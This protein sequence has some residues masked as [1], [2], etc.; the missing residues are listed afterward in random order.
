MPGTPIASLEDK[1][2]RA[3]PTKRSNKELIFIFENDDGEQQFVMI[4][5]VN[6]FPYHPFQGYSTLCLSCLR[7]ISA[8]ATV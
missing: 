2:K 5:T 4:M 3:R 7:A 6:L 8:C 1:T